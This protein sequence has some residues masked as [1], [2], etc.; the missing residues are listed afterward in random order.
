MHFSS[1]QD[2]YVLSNGVKIPCIGFGTWRLDNT[3]ESIGVIKKAIECGYRHIDTAAGYDNENVVGRAVA[4]S[5]LPR[6]DFFITTKL[7][8][9]DHGYEKTI[10]AFNSSLQQL[11]MDYV[12]LYLVHWPNPMMYRDCWK[13][14]N[15]ES[16][17]AFEEFYA[18]GKIRALGISN[19]MPHHIEA[20]MESAKVL[21][22][23]N[24]IFLCPGVTQEHSI[25]YSRKYDMLPVAYSP[26]GAAKSLNHQYLN[27][28]SV[29]Y[30]KTPAQ[31]CL[32]WSLH[33][34]YLPIP[35]S[36]TIQR[37]KENIDIFDFYLQEDEVTRL[38]YIKSFSEEPKNPDLV[39]F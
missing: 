10:A 33:M 17:K 3:K 31:I 8:N 5:G 13:K 7:N 32:R 1:V 24:Q 16:W 29:K 18:Q 34:G 9:P 6:K 36:S 12:D 28:L 22:A 25:S 4:E 35:K 39:E 30:N 21:P 27:E 19:F 20:L 14:K 23:V 26:L 2:S 11:G 37:M 38:C 15:A